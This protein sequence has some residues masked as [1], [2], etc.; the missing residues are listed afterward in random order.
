MPRRARIVL[1]G[2]PHHITQR[3][4]RRQET[5]FDDADY[6]LYLDLLAR[7]VGSQGMACWAWCLMPNHVHLVLVPRR[8]DDLAAVMQRV[9]QAYTREVNAR[10]GWSGCLWQ[11]RFASYAMDEAHCLAAIRY[12]EL[13]PVKARLVSRA[14]DWV[15]SSASAHVSGAHDPLLARPEF[16]ER[17]PDW[18][19]YLEAALP[20]DIEARIGH[21]DGP[22]YPKGE[23]SW[24]ARLETK[25]Q[26]ELRPKPKGRPQREAGD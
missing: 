8:A 16:L 3:G 6:A 11:G 23:P 17:I 18:Q 10:E 12:V 13:N 1:P 15:W 24:L 14:Q 19:R 4:N 7:H 5:F 20:P 26:R 2:Y 25:L 21:F 9:H 22:G